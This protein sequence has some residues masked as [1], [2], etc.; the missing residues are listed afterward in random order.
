[1][2]QEPI[3]FNYKP[4]ESKDLPSSI[5]A[6][7]QITLL[8]NPA[9]LTLN[10]KKII[11][12]TRTKSRIVSFYWGQEPVNFTYSGQTGSVYPTAQEIN[13]E[14]RKL[15][16]A[17]TDG[18]EELRAR[19]EELYTE[20]TQRE[21]QIAAGPLFETDQELQT[22]LDALRAERNSNELNASNLTTAASTLT[23][24]SL[25]EQ[26]HTEL[27]E[28]SA[29]YRAFKK[30]QY[31]FEKSQNVNDLMQIK[32]RS[33]IFKGYL[34]NFSFTDDGS[35]PW[36]WIYNISFTILEWDETPSNFDIDELMLVADE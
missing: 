19:N 13:N 31:L 1:M 29:K 12:R 34:E 27:I 14:V 25:G 3:I 8:I 4:D 36:N 6:L 9:S 32:Y 35:N 30:L 33:Y 10:W 20:I 11:T 17:H 2:K 7:P 5:V 15:G 21:E 24:A 26:S 16:K 23:P 18:A 28:M 22:E